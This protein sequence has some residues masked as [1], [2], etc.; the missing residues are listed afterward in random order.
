MCPPAC[1]TS[2]AQRRLKSVREAFW[3]KTQPACPA[4]IRAALRDYSSNEVQLSG[5]CAAQRCTPT[6]ES[7]GSAPMEGGS[8]SAGSS[9][10]APSKGLPKPD[11]K[12]PRGPAT[13]ARRRV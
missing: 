1:T 7:E 9:P 11:P 3:R 5:T 4:K 8:A 10:P 2:A 13:Y 12:K 6:T